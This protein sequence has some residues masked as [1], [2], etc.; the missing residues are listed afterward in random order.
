VGEAM[1][2]VAARLNVGDARAIAAK[3][4][5]DALVVMYRPTDEGL[6]VFAL[7]AG[8]VTASVVKVTAAD[9]GIALRDYRRRLDQRADVGTVHRDLARWLIAPIAPRLE[10]KKRLAIVAQGGLK[11]VAFAALPL[12]EGAVVDRLAT[13]HAPDPTAAVAALAATAAP[14]S[15]QS[16]TALAAPQSDDGTDAPLAFA[17]REIEVI[18][19][20]HPGAELVDGALA[21]KARYV[22]ALAGSGG[23]VHFAGHSRLSTGDPLSSTLRT[24]GPPLALHEVLTGP[25][26]S[27][28]TVLSACETLGAPDPALSAAAVARREPVSFSDAFLFAGA[29]AVL[30]TTIRV[31]DVSAAILMKRFY[32]AARTLP[33]AQALQAAQQAARSLDPHPAAWA[34]FGLVVAP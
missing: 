24:A 15:G 1:P 29:D 12:G 10:G 28:L 27:S 21:T 6:V 22:Q 25:S 3:A 26:A 23:V 31:D 16:I 18:K 17:S 7:D 4:P 30:A 34:T 8:T 11:L 33:A 5:P 13:M 2:A 20:S 9:L 14:L 19:E 32:R